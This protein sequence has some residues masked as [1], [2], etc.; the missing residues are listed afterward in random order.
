MLKEAVNIEVYTSVGAAFL[1][2]F[3]SFFSGTQTLLLVFSTM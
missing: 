3:Q 2:K 1:M